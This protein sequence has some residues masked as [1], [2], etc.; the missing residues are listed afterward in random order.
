MTKALNT[1]LV[2]LISICLY[3]GYKKNQ[4]PVR[5]HWPAVTQQE[6]KQT[7]TQRNPFNVAV[8]GQ[9]HIITPLF[10]YEISGLVVSCHFSKTLAEYRRDELNIMDAGI[11]W[12]Q[13]L[14][15]AIYTLMKFHNN[16]VW[17]HYKASS[18]EVY[19]KFDNDKI[20][21][22]HLLCTNSVIN[23]KIKALKRG[24]VIT[25]EGCLA[26]YT[27]QNGSRGSSTVR[28][29]HGNGACETVWVNQL[30]LL[31]SGN[32]YWRLAFTCCLSA[33]FGLILFRIIRFFIV[34][35][36]SWKPQ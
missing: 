32:K 27:L 19:K 23:K 21:N 24:D 34:I 16:G 12:G 25:L 29:D 13:N 17:L 5:N 1:I 33:L 10:N 3:T 31:E 7:P 6:P 9:T 4:L 2:L 8:G 26:T 30:T 35:H 20:S 18:H 11:I 22:N 14:N 15:P 28:T 36:R